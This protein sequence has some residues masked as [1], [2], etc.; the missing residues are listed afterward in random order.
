MGVPNAWLTALGGVLIA[1]ECFSF[2][3]APRGWM[4][5][6]FGSGSH[7]MVVSA[8]LAVLVVAGSGR[9]FSALPRTTISLTV[10]VLIVL[11]SSILY[12]YACS[13]YYLGSGGDFSTNFHRPDAFELAASNLTNVGLDSAKPITQSAKAMVLSQGASDLVFV[14]LF[15]AIAIGK[16]VNGIKIRNY[17][18]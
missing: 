15:V 10:T 13:Y 1:L 16:I 11:A 2:A 8:V 18:K 9:L 6:T 4:R 14:V 7:S 5:S 12:V 3:Y 17:E